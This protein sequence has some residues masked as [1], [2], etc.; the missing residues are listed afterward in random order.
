MYLKA[1]AL[2]LI[3]IIRLRFPQNESISDILRRRYDNNAVLLFRK[4][5]R[6]DFKIR[7][8]KQDIQF[9]L[10]CVENNLKPTF[11]KFRTSNRYLRQ[12]SAYQSCQK[13]LIEEE[14][15]NKRRILRAHER[16]F[17][18]LKLRL[19]DTI[20]FLDF[21]HMF[22]IIKRA[23]DGK[24]DK[25][26]KLQERKLFN[27]GLKQHTGLKADDIIHNFS[28]YTL[29]THEKDLLVRGL[30]FA[31]PPEK[32]NYADFMLP[33]E[34]LFQSVKLFCKK[35]AELDRIR[36]GLKGTAFYA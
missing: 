23:N 25:V 32:I 18:D 3:F 11:V 19:K 1:V 33:F 7:K 8:V 13:K 27:L 26:I 20:S 30:N 36:T 29:S 31:L 16:K 12:T 28:S 4:F 22:G 14:L 24:M 9:L 5:E 35:P 10:K 6:I 2:V 34:L 17:D 21:C 15:N